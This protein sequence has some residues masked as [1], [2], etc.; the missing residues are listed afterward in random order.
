M[1]PTTLI[2]VPDERWYDLS[3]TIR[4]DGYSAQPMTVIDATG[5]GRSVLLGLQ[6]MTNGEITLFLVEPRLASQL[7]WELIGQAQGF[8]DDL[9]EDYESWVGAEEDEDE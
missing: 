2:P 7:G 6:D 9:I 8:V 5:A 3:K 1:A 4:I